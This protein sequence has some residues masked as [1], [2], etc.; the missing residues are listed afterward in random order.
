MCVTRGILDIP[1]LWLTQVSLL[2]VFDNRCF[3][4]HEPKQFAERVLPNYFRQSKFSS[5]RRQLN[6]YGF[7]R[8][9]TGQDKNGMLFKGPGSSLKREDCVLTDAFLLSPPQA[10]TMRCSYEACRS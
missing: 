9:T 4:V 6:L 8:L 2:A 1:L 3:L 10:I 5:F 7:K